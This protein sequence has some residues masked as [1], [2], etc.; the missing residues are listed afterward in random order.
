[1]KRSAFMFLAIALAGT[2]AFAVR[3][4]AF[5]PCGP[6]LGGYLAILLILAGLPAGA[7][8]LAIAG[9]RAGWRCWRHSR[10]ETHLQLNLH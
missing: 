6:T 10:T 2:L 7:L 1:M 8:L 3:L 9:G 5:G 4:A